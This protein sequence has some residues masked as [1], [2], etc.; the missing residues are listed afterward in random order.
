M[1]DFPPLINT[2]VCDLWVSAVSFIYVYVY[3]WE[4][5]RE[6]NFYNVY[7]TFY[8]HMILTPFFM[9]FLWD[10]FNLLCYLWFKQL[11]P[12]L[13]NLHLNFS[14]PF[15]YLFRFLTIGNSLTCLMSNWKIANKLYISCCVSIRWI[16]K[17]K[18]GT[19]LSLGFDA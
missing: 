9:I 13:M 14:V 17:I 16:C 6:F 4:R 10:S 8:I 19:W 12:I 7:D 3:I 11:Q 18:W 1:I 5:E 2:T 15:I